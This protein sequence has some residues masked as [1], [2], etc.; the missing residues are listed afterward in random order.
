METADIVQ[1][2][3][4]PEDLSKVEEPEVLIN[5]EIVEENYDTGDEDR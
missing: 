5:D 4:T 3:D 1:N 2:E